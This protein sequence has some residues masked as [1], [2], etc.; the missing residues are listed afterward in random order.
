MTQNSATDQSPAWS[1]DGTWIAF[2]TNRDGDTEIYAIPVFGDSGSVNLTRAT[3]DD[4]SP[5]WTPLP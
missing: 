3:G 5:A 4:W 1:A 2:E